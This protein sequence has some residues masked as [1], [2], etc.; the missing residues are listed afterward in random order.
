MF[1]SFI[2]IISENSGYL[3]NITENSPQVMIPSRSARWTPNVI[4]N[5]GKLLFGM[6]FYKRHIFIN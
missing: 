6:I 3:P 1:N 2:N 4:T 5:P